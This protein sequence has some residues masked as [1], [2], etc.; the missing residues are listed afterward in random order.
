VD[1]RGR[2]RVVWSHSD[3]HTLATRHVAVSRCLR[4]WAGQTR[5]ESVPPSSSTTAVVSFI[6]N[7]IDVVCEF[8]YKLERIWVATDSCGLTT[9]H[10]AY[11]TLQDTV[12]PSLDIPADLNLYCTSSPPEHEDASSVS[13]CGD[14]SS[15]SSEDS[16]VDE[17]CVHNYTVV[18]TWTA[19]DACGLTTT[20]SQS[21]NIYDHVPPAFTS[22][23]LP[24]DEEIA[25][26]GQSTVAILT[27][28]DEC[29]NGVEVVS[30]ETK[31]EGG[32]PTNF[33]LNRLWETEDKCGNKRV[34][35]QTVKFYDAVAPLVANVLNRPSCVIPTVVDTSYTYPH[36]T[37]LV[38]NP[39]FLVNDACSTVSITLLSRTSN[40]DSFYEVESVNGF[41]QDCKCNAETDSLDLLV[42]AEAS[43]T[44]GR[45][46]TIS[47]VATD[48]CGNAAPLSHQIWVPLNADS[49]RFVSFTLNVTTNCQRQFV[50][51]PECPCEQVG[52]S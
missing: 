19:V 7:R 42:R 41:T 31:V 14:K 51:G 24:T 3:A 50:D 40:L 2:M 6:E 5:P 39:F 44:E 10:V 49:L 11:I 9:T 33:T 27:A 17:T 28:L 25:C 43:F 12:A 48:A 26:G 13:N 35:Q 32:C 37:S 16:K 22:S 36:V 52:L 29:D 30:T 15:L 34:H 46:F 4:L 18:R 8:N 47:G 23:S 20:R 21:I 38:D 45:T 1:G